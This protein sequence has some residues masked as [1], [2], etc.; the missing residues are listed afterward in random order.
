MGKKNDMFRVKIEYENIP[1]AD[2]KVKGFV[3]MD[4]LFKE[5]KKKFKGGK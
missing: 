3:G 1:I 2:S 4:A 5:V